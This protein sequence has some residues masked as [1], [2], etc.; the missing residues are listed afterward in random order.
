MEVQHINAKIF[1]E[2]EMGVDPREFIAI[3]QRWVKEQ[4][5]EELLIDMADYRH[6][7]NG[8]G[9]LCVGLQADY[10]MDHQQGRWGILYNRKAPL[11]GA[12]ADRFA[13][14]LRS[15]AAAGERLE[16]EAGGGLRFSRKEFELV[17]NDRAA[18]TNSDADWAAYKADV[19]SF[20]GKLTGGS[21]FSVERFSPD[22]R[23]RLGARVK[24]GKPASLT[25]P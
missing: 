6:V 3:F 18:A 15:A 2:G 4:H 19:E 21:D 8:P 13:Q 17:V 5:R 20:L 1:V 9:V 24:L 10:G 25:A 7:P 14:A 22:P 12:N 23:A 16:S 11:A